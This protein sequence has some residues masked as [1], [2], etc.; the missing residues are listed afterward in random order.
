MPNEQSSINVHSK[1]TVNM[2]HG[3]QKVDE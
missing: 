2:G 1:D 3:T